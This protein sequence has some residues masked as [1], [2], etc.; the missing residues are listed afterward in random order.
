MFVPPYA[1]L[2]DAVRSTET[3]RPK[4]GHVTVPTALLRHL[5]TMILRDGAFDAEQYVAINGQAAALMERG[6][7][8]SAKEHF[9]AQ[10]YFLGLSGGEAAFDEEW[11]LDAY[12]DVREAVRAGR[13][14][15]GEAHYQAVGMH[16]WRS[17]NAASRIQ[18]ETWRAAL[19]AGQGAADAAH[20]EVRAE[21]A[22]PRA[23][24]RG[25]APAWHERLREAFGLLDRSLA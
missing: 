5:L 20:G 14:A 19:G 16:E 7:C 3:A 9:A 23:P 18:L 13:F 15:S 11:Y 1:A 24:T 22:P 6:A 8:A 17:P 4:D 2:L 10:G 21:T 12:P 25:E